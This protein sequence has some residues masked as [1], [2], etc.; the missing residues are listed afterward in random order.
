MEVTFKVD[1]KMLKK[2]LD[3]AIKSYKK[4]LQHKMR[5]IIRRLA[6]EIAK[7][8]AEGTYG[9]AITVTTERTYKGYK[10]I[11]E[12]EAVCFLEF[13]AGTMTNSGHEFAS[14]M[15]FSVYPGS[16]S[17][18]HAKEFSTNGYWTFSGKRYYYVEP[19]PGMYEAYKAIT[20]NVY[21][22]A[23]EEFSK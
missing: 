9:R 3:G 21:R 22:I 8:A 4:V 7:P 18:N 2:G 13:G 15:P 5:T 6:K 12:G 14:K 16:W 11:A 20:N 17:E 10:I 1:K 19:R 23:K